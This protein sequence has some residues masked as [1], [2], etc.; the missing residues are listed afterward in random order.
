[1]EEVTALPVVHGRRGDPLGRVCDRGEDD[2][3]Y[4]SDPHAHGVTVGHHL[5]A[6]T[7]RSE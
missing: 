5:D 1:M 6:A 2:A 7:F 4:A 3:R